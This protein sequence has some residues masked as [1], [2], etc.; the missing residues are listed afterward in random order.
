ML[1]RAKLIRQL[2]APRVI[3]T[4]TRI[5]GLAAAVSDFPAPLG[6]RCQIHRDGTD[7]I[8]GEVVGFTGEETLVLPFGA[9]VRSVTITMPQPRSIARTTAVTTYGWRRTSSMGEL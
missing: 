5:V 4:T 9:C 6:A 1:T 8:D 2:Q 3:G 7:P